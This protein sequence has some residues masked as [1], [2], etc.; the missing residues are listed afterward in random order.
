MAIGK[1]KRISKGGRRG[2]RGRVVEAMSRKEWYDVVAPAGFEN[3]QFAKT[4]CNKTAGIRIAADFLRGRVYESNLADLN[5]TA[6]HDDAYRKVRFAVQEVQGRNLLTQ[7]HSMEM[8]S[9]R[10]ASLFRKWCTTMECNVDVRTADGYQLRLFVIAFT[11]KMD[12]Q[13]SQ[14]CYAKSRLVRWV[15]QRITN[16]TKRRLSKVG[17]SEAVALLTRDILADN[18]FKRCNPIVPMRDLR[19]SKVK[20]VRTPKY[21]PQ[22]LLTAHGAIPASI[23]GETVEVEEAAEAAPAVQATA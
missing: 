13:L 14:N 3:R 19:I 11:K 10:M 6:G 18:L 20:V 12:N 8:T 4:I 23:E 7:F 16:M 9:D 1:N 21:D 15:R 17:I 22:A 5:K 2:K